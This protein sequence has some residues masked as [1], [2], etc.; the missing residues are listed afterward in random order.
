MNF[1]I[2]WQTSLQID[3]LF[4]LPLLWC[5]SRK[6]TS[7]NKPSFYTGN[8]LLKWTRK[9]KT[10]VYPWVF[11]RKLVR[12]AWISDIFLWSCTLQKRLFFWSLQPEEKREWT[13]H[14][15][16]SLVV[17]P[18]HFFSFLVFLGY[19]PFVHSKY[20]PSGELPVEEAHLCFNF[21]CLGLV[22]LVY[23]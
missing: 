14:C 1:F 17:L 5:H 2:K 19:Y 22:F 6:S 20:N 4:P 21:Y 7:Y 15:F 8:P 11:C 10:K 13:P 18:S 3:C 16:D 23:N 9:M 12:I